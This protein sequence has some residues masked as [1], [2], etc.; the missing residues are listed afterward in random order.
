MKGLC[1]CG[2]A[3]L[4]AIGA[5]TTVEG[6]AAGAADAAMRHEPI[7]FTRGISAHRAVRGRLSFVIPDDWTANGHL[8]RAPVFAGQVPA[9][10][11]QISVVIEPTAVTTSAPSA[12]QVDNRL[13]ASRRVVAMGRGPRPHGSWGVDET[14]IGAMGSR[15][16]VSGVGVVHV[17][18]RVFVHIRVFTVL[19]MP[20][21]QTRC[22]DDD[23]RNGVVAAA[24]TRIV[25]SAKLRAKIAARHS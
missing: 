23:V 9:T 15:R 20:D 14:H 21:H 12:A 25:R 7:T 3:G 1:L 13:L 10:G 18:A 17:A 8:G 4:A 19:D 24:V 11:C 16:D 5:L 22:S 2:L 6:G